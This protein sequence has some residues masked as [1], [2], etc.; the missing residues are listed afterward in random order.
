MPGI[1]PDPPPPLPEELPPLPP[2]V[3]IAA[4]EPPHVFYSIGENADG[5]VYRTHMSELGVPDGCFEVTQSVY[6]EASAKLSACKYEDGALIDVPP[7]VM[8]FPISRRQLAQAM[9]ER[10]VIGWAEAEDWTRGDT[11][12]NTV[13]T[14]I[15][16]EP[17]EEQSRVRMYLL[18]QDTFHREHQYMH[19]LA[20]AYE[21]DT[22]EF[23]NLWD[24]ASTLT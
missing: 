8:R 18:S 15:R 7:P 4:P 10:G 24:Y 5:I 22:T 21:Y 16:S 12:P 14:V 3:P 6:A 9:A 17:S 19:L 20:S 1:I 13:A 23:N 2:E 11:I